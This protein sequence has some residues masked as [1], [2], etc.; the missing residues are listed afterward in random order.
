MKRKGHTYDTLCKL[1]TGIGRGTSF[2][3][4]KDPVKEKKKKEKK[5]DFR[6]ENRSTTGGRKLISFVMKESGEGAQ[7]RLQQNH[8]AS[9]PFKKGGPKNLG[10]GVMRGQVG[11]GSRPPEGKGIKLGKIHTREPSKGGK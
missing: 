2:G 7:K 3:S 6:Q 9:P 5:Q 11:R 8:W 1:R 4:T 10:G